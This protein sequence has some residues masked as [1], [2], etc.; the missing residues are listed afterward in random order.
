[1]KFVKLTS[2]VGRD[3]LLSVLRDYETVNAKVRF[4]E[5]RGKPAIRVK[6]KDGRVRITCEMIGGPSKDNG[7]FVGT[8]FK[9]RISERDGVTTLKGIITTAP[10]YHLG[11]AI[12]F[13]FFI[14]QCIKVG[15]FSPIPIIA[16]LFSLWM[17]KGEF[18]K[19]GIISRYLARA[20]KRAEENKK[21]R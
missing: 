10:I 6:E 14:Y 16:L 18:G 21:A 15:G 13:G 5:K 11:L 17:F 12:L 19:Q 3:E 2:S 9:G 8:Y 20:V 1:M 4:D 7:F